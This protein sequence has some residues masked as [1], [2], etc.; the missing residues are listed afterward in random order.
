MK[1]RIKSNFQ[2]PNYKAVL[3]CITWFVNCD[4]HY[5]AELTF[6]IK[7]YV[8]PELIFKPNHPLKIGCPLPQLH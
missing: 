5:A 6:W 7:P 8:L 1:L 2:G 3:C 4:C